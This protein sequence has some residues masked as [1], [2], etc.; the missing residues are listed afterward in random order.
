MNAKICAGPKAGSARGAIR[1]VL[2]YSLGSHEHDLAATPEERKEAFHSLLAEASERRD[3]G[4]GVVFAPAQGRGIRPSS[5]YAKN[6]A[7]LATADIE[8]DAV[9]SIAASRNV[10]E[11]AIHFVFSVNPHESKNTS[12]EALIRAAETALTHVGLGS[13][14]QV[15]S[16]HRD[17]P[18]AH[19]HV[20][21]AAVD[22]RSLKVWER[23]R[24]RSRLSW[25]TREAELQHHMPHDRGLAVVRTDEGG[26]Q[27]IEW[28]SR[29]EKAA[30]ARERI[31]ERLADQARRY[32]ADY[33]GY[34]SAESWARDVVAPRIRETIAIAEE[35][36]ETPRWAD[37]HAIAATFGTRIEKTEDGA[38]AIQMMERAEGEGDH[39][40]GHDLDHDLDERTEAA[41][42]LDAFGEPIPERTVTQRASAEPAIVLSRED[43]IGPAPL[44]D[45]SQHERRVYERRDAWLDS[46][47][48]VEQSEADFIAQVR[49]NPSLI[50]RE[51][52]AGG[53]AAF[54]RGDIDAFLGDR[55][56]DADTIDK[57]SQYVERH[58][59]TLVMLSADAEHPLFTTKA[60]LAL[61]REVERKATLLAHERDPFFSRRALDRAIADV[62][63]ERGIVIS[64]EQR[65]VLDGLAYRL[66]WVNGDAGTGK[67]TIMAVTNRYCEYTNRPIVGFTTA[68]AAAEKLQQESG[69]FALNSTRALMREQIGEQIV[70]RRATVMLDET[71]MLDLH[72]LDRT[73]YLAHERHAM[74]I[75]IGDAAQ[76]PAI[77]AADAH[78]LM[79]EVARE[80]GTYSELHDVRR[81]KGE[82]VWMRPV[83]SD[84]GRAIRDGDAHGV[85]RSVLEM[86]KHDVFHFEEDRTA[87]FQAAARRYVTGNA[88]G[89]EV[90][91][92]VATRL[93]A[94]H[95]NQTI[96]SEIG[97]AGTGTPFRTQHGVCEVAVGD[98]IVFERN[99]RTLG[100][101]NGYTATVE[102]V[103]YDKARDA[104]TITAKLDNGRRISFD[105]VRYRDLGHGYA[106][107]THKVQGQSVQTDV[108]VMTKSADARKAFVGMTRGEHALEVYVSKEAYA[109]TQDLAYALAQRIEGKSDAILFQE[110][111][112]RTGGPGTV[113]AQ[114]VTR[115]MREER[116]PLRQQHVREAAKLADLRE[117]RLRAAAER[118]RVQMKA[119]TPEQKKAIG[120]QYR[121]EVA[122]IVKE[123]K[124]RS[125]VQWAAEHRHR[126][127]SQTERAAA[128]RRIRNERV[129]EAECRRVAQARIGRERDR[130]QSR[131]REHGGYSR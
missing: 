122:R 51:I 38:F 26:N 92:N 64:D 90:I 69:A 119:A 23:H 94:K 4:V 43:L 99:S 37:I 77:G 28:A 83:V 39:S 58:D 17:T 16:V 76:L 86:G 55:I 118:Q 93:E 110:I 7:S 71:S 75:G 66:S 68:Q 31:E 19:V 61:E 72:A 53:E 27:R 14:A 109:T 114:N 88:A 12:D 57:L 46:Y 82:L 108:Y 131:S 126:I 13:H 11:S 124:P 35:R 103:R 105:P 125:F 73:L 113:W 3:F 42:R 120:A 70:G 111:V 50:S 24:S 63:R 65:R 127:E 123:T 5:V 85:E 2:G 67:T 107:T 30:W 6:V 117:R 102:D 49:G 60:Q 79:S 1:Y 10:R 129:L 80:A 52:V 97:I 121:A 84:L 62:E 8:M 98:R 21:V 47:A 87:T 59:D 20:V 18:H 101:L 15:Y 9:A 78:R 74:I 45:A 89:E 22:A 56:S 33:V 44:V 130:G 41:Q 91:L 95:L 54:T 48:D 29:A 81:Q 104:W 116:A 100:V 106:V 128:L 34:E 112:K 32:A 115:A 25:A 36:G 40:V 96:R